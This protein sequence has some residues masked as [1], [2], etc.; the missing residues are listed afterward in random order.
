M[1]SKGARYSRAQAQM[2]WGLPLVTWSPQQWWQEIFEQNS[3][4][5]WNLG[6]S[7]WDRI[8]KTEY[9]V[10][11]SWLTSDEEI[12]DSGFRRKG[13]ANPFGWMNRTHTGKLP[14]KD[15]YNQVLCWPANWRQQFAPNAKVHCRR[16]NSC[17]MVMHSHTQLPRPLK[18][19]TNWVLRCWNTQPCL[20]PISWPFRILYHWTAQ[21]WFTD[22]D[23]KELVHKWLH[24]QL[25]TFLVRIRKLVDHWVKCIKKEEDYYIE[26]RCSCLSAAFV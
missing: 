8:Q 23:G 22:E 24:D 16:K 12:K 11:T 10:E 1:S 4:R 26:K 5:R 21:R 14:G 2:S 13:D 20:Q 25:E 15:V 18:S 9:G 17:Y 6:P 7:L 3:H 19:L